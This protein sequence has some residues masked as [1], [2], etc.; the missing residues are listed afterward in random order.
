MLR[1]ALCFGTSGPFLFLVATWNL[2]G[3]RILWTCAMHPIS[4]LLHVVLW[5]SCY[6]NWSVYP[7]C[8][9]LGRTLDVVDDVVVAAAVVVVLQ[10]FHGRAL[11]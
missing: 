4:H 5:M 3:R 10:R 1:G 7:F 8:R 11:V 6:E 9:D 2:W